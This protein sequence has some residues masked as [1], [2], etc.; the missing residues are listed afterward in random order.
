MSRS[1]VEVCY[2]LVNFLQRDEAD[3]QARVDYLKSLAQEEADAEKALKGE[4]TRE[5]EVIPTTGS[6][7]SSADRKAF[8]R[9]KIIAEN[10]AAKGGEREKQKSGRGGEGGEEGEEEEFVG[11]EGADAMGKMLASFDDSDDEES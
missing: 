8:L 11:D 5:I 6:P 1:A 10:L 3:K 7:G 4:G 9:D 2:N